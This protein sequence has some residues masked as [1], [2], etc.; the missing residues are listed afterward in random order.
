[1]VD[2]RISEIQEWMPVE[3]HAAELKAK[4]E[5]IEKLK[6]EVTILKLEKSSLMRSLSGFTGDA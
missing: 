5:L 6:T 3:A 2:E 1:M 4:D